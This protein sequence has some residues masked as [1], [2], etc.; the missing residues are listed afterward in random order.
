[1]PMYHISIRYMDVYLYDVRL[2][3]RISWIRN[4]RCYLL[5][6]LTWNK[7]KKKKKVIS[8]LS[9]DLLYNTLP[10]PPSLR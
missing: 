8:F 1:M 10:L 2:S 5:G 4:D 9:I 3:F 6:L 7:Q